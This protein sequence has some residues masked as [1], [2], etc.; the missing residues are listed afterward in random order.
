MNMKIDPKISKV[1]CEIQKDTLIVRF[2]EPMK[3][4]SSAVL[5]SGLCKARAII[6]HHVPKSFDHHDP[7][8]VLRDLVKDLGL[9]DDT[10]G[11]MTAVKIHNIA[12]RIEK[13][14]ELTVSALVTAGL[15]YPATASDD[16]IQ[17]NKE[18]TINII[19]LIDGNLTEGCMINC[20]QTAIE[21]KT[22]AL[23]ELDIRSRFSSSVAS[24]STT[25][26]IAVVCTGIGEPIKFAGTGT[27][28]GI[29]IGKA[30]KEATK[31][32]IQKQDGTVSS[33]S[34]I[35]RLKE[36]GITI[37]DM[38]NSGLE[39]FIPSHEIENKEKA[40]ELLR[41]GLIRALSDFNI[42]AL[43]LAAL[44]LQ[45]DG[46]LGLIPNLPKDEFLKDPISLIADENVGI[47]IANYISG[48]WGFYNFLYFERKKPG[49]IKKLGPFL[50]DA[51]GG[52]IA[53][54]LSKIYKNKR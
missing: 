16:T 47:A 7:E 8:S 50:D 24:G 53:G 14:K 5:N 15:S 4:L 44:R 37:D 51:I 20:I 49:I 34:I 10:V 12:I 3:V 6:N 28:I 43:I 23:R 38:I 48:T 33:R 18:S 2:D 17:T 19:L 45:E 27:E 30:V 31:E 40:S 21:A 46:E 26:A 35:E 9:P 29:V 22:V 41:E 1:K 25:D 54:V 42:S 13:K 32:A 39:L 36:R 52:L 11:F